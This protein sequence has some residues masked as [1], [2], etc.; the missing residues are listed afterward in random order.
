MAAGRGEAGWE[1]G[2][3]PKFEWRWWPETA[4]VALASIDQRRIECASIACGV[5]G[6]WRPWDGRPCWRGLLPHHQGLKWARENFHWMQLLPVT[7]TNNENFLGSLPERQPQGRRAVEV[8]GDRLLLSYD[9]PCFSIL[10]QLAIMTDQ[11]IPLHILILHLVGRAQD[12]SRVKGEA[13]YMGRR[14]SW[15]R[16][17]C[18]ADLMWM[19]KLA[20]KC[21]SVPEWAFQGFVCINAAPATAAPAFRRRQV[22]LSWTRVYQASCAPPYLPPQPSVSRSVVCRH[23]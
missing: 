7:A 3:A 4:S 20:T 16:N 8:G 2:E 1:R 12:L 18:M 14:W 22:S 17:C 11:F 6:A 19:W 10:L 5:Q 21:T 15:L 13:A 9:G 23:G